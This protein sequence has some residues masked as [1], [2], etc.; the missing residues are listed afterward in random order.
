VRTQRKAHRQLRLAAIAAIALTVPRHLAAQPATNGT[1]AVVAFASSADIGLGSPPTGLQTIYI[2]DQITGQVSRVGDCACAYPL[3][4]SLDGTRLA[5]R[6]DGPAA[7]S[8]AYVKSA[9][10][11]GPPIRVDVADDGPTD[12]DGTLSGVP[13]LSGNG[14]FVAFASTANL[15][16]ADGDTPG[17]PD[18][19]VRDLVAGRTQRWTLGA[20]LSGSPSI[21]A[22]GRYVAFATPSQL[23]PEDSNQVSD[24]YLLDRMASSS[25]LRLVTN[26]ALNAA[27]AGAA[28]AAGGSAVAFTSGTDNLVP[29]GANRSADVFVVDLRAGT[30]TRVSVSAGAGTPSSFV[31]ISGNGRRVLFAAAT[32]LYLHDLNSGETTTV[33]SP[34]AVEPGVTTALSPDGHTAFLTT[35][36]TAAIVA[37][38][39]P[40]DAPAGSSVRTDPFDPVAGRNP[41]TLTFSNVTAPG[42]VSLT[43]TTAGPAMPDGLRAVTPYFNVTADARTEDGALVCLDAPDTTSLAAA[44]RFLRFDGAAWVD[45][46]ALPADQGTSVCGHA[47]AVGTFVFATRV[48]DAASSSSDNRNPGSA[49]TGGTSS[50]ASSNIVTWNVDANG[51]WDIPT[52][53]SGGVV[54]GDGD[55]VIIDRPSGNF[56]VTVRTTTANVQSVQSAEQLVVTGTLIVSGTASFNGGLALSGTLTGTGSATLSPTASSSWIGGPNSVIS[57][58]GGMTV[59][60][61]GALTIGISPGDFPNHFLIDSSLHV[62]G[63]VIWTYGAVTISNSAVTVE[64]DGLWEADNDLSLTSDANGVRTLTNLGT[65]RKAS[66]GGQLTLGGTIAFANTGTIDLQAGTIGVTSD[67]QLINSGFLKLAAGTAFLLDKV[68]LQGGS[69][70][71]GPGQLQANGTTTVTGNVTVTAPLLITGQ[72]TGTG[73]LHLDASA[74]W[75]SNGTTTISVAGGVDVMAARTLT[76]SAAP[77]Q[78]HYLIDSSLHSSGTVVWTGGGLILNGSSTVT[79][80][81]GGLW[82]IQGD[83]SVGSQGAGSP[84]FTNSGTLRKSA[85]PGTLTLG[86]SVVYANTGTIDVQSGILAVGGQQLTSSGVMQVATGVTVQLDRVTLQNGST[87]GGPGLLH[88]NGLTTI[89]GNVTITSPLLITG[90]VTGTG[91]LHLSAATTWQSNGTTIIS[92]A[93]GVDVMTGQ[94]MTIAA[95]PGQLHY[96]I[97]SSLRNHGTVVWTAGGLD[98]RNGSTVTNDAGRL[99]DTQGDLSIIS[100]GIGSPAFT[101]LGTLRKSAG[102]GTLTLGGAVVYTNTGT[103]DLQSGLLTVTSAGGLNTSGPLQVTTGTTFQLDRVTLQATS[104]FSGAGLLHANGLTTITGA[105]TVTAPLLITAEVTGTGTLRLSA[106]TTWQS[107]G[108]TIISVAGGVDVMAGR[109]LTVSAAPGQLHYLIDSSLHNHGTVAWTSGGLQL[110]N[111][112]TVTNETDG[113]WDVQASQSVG[114]DGT[115]TPAF[116]NNGLLRRSGAPNRLTIA[117]P[118]TNTG[119]FAVRIG[120][121][122]AGQLDEF[123]GGAVNLNGTLSAQFINGFTPGA[124]DQFKVMEYPSIS[125]A[126]AT[127]TGDGFTFSACYTPTALF[128]C[129]VSTVKLTPTITW[130]NP[131]DIPFGTALGVTQLNATASVPGTFAYVPAAGTILNAGNNQSLQVTFTP[132][133]TVHYNNAAANVSINVIRATPTITWANPASIVYG[134]ALSGTQLNAT[135]SVP[136]AFAY[137]PATGAKLHAGNNQLLS[138]TFTPTD[139]A[140]YQPAGKS[141]TI[142]VLRAPL[143]VTAVNANK[144]FGAP[145]PTFTASFNGFVNGDTS[146]NLGGTLSFTTTA[147]ATSPAGGYPIVPGGLSSPDYTIAFQSGTLTIAPAATQTSIFVLPATVGFLQPVYAIAVVAPVA[148]GAGV[149][150]GIVQFKEGA[151]VLG[152]ATVTSNIAYLVLNGLAP[153]VHNL[154]AAYGGSSN[155]AASLSSAGSAT[156]RP[157][158]ASTFT[159][160][161]AQTNPQASGQP[162][163]LAAAVIPL[164]G[165][166]PTGTVQFMEGNTV[167]GSAAIA[168]GIATINP[169]TLSVGT[170]LLSAKYLGNAAFAATS[171]PPA[172]ITIYSGARPT[173]TASSLT[174]SAGTSTL[175]F[176]VT[177]T[178]TVTGGATSGTVSFYSDGVPIGDAPLALAGGSFKATLTT[179]VLSTGIHVVSASYLGSAGFSSST[180]GPVVQIVQAP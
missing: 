41:L 40:P 39:L 122:G 108:T 174:S 93:G 114:F 107:N 126:F 80:E 116:V 176:P 161:I 128:V 79:N 112:S 111:S 71:A 13:A 21:S 47:G 120:G 88:A 3:S 69:T 180:S 91:T 61:G 102:P 173:T 76:I 164:G 32:R 12:A 27:A 57:L 75:H 115:G 34:A 143:T 160:F 98:L 82:D 30:T 28:I 147:T 4:L 136:G 135:A 175:G 167:I 100:D 152:S 158:A 2:K 148:P 9:P 172:A 177:F 62:H 84:A 159:F 171:S 50:P 6:V 89:S 125:G 94:T 66:T 117:T 153:G 63:A 36:G 42:N 127:L 157:L 129:S 103:I 46:A 154:T 1:G 155:F 58:A 130:A 101:N 163:T 99:W 51:F 179:A 166:T 87:F 149:P 137:T 141:V 144:V 162:A 74:T 83:V 64:S 132:T 113:L 168:G 109:T 54:P 44:V 22:D 19:F 55:T 68:T 133:D 14:R 24:V 73:T 142:S 35:P 77:G 67:Q 123:G 59:P 53:W 48:S 16:R 43:I 23:L 15:D 131:A 45:E 169:T 146:G 8:A 124:G 7:I 121:L 38:P 86:G 140:N 17:T 25:N 11:T 60:A 10:F 150:A 170:H 97:D 96:L 106:A 37:I 49:S 65:L 85:G 72:V 105:V 134:I 119:T 90:E 31:S 95:L 139:T 118:F 78:L 56:V 20:R 81:A 156:V 178:A 165:G 104:T 29:G 92:V 18:L 33:D 110:R 70:F 138:V 52:N 26:P 145:L 151:S 5:F